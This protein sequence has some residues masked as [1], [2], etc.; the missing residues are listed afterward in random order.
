[1]E[2]RIFAER[3]LTGDRLQ[4][5]LF[6]PEVLSDGAPGGWGSVPDAPGR[7]AE[8]PLRSKERPPFPGASQL[9]DS[10]AAVTALHAFANH[11]LLAIELMALALLR[12][13]DAD[14]AF[15]MD[16]ALTLQEEQRHLALYVERMEALGSPFG[17]RTLSAF[18]WDT[19]A[20][21]DSPAGFCA[22]MGLTL[23]QANLDF[24]G[25]FAEAFDAVGDVA[26]ARVL[27]RVLADEI[28]HVA[29]GLQWFDRFRVEGDRFDAYLAALPSPLTPRRA[30]G[31]GF[32]V[33]ARLR[34]G[35]DEDFI[36][37][38][39]AYGASRGRAAD[40]HWLNR[41]AE[42]GEG[43][44]AE[45]WIHDLEATAVLRTSP[46]DV[47]LVSRRPGVR[48]LEQVSAAG[49][50]VPALRLRTDG[51]GGGPV[52]QV[53][54]WAP[55]VAAAE[56][57][58]PWGEVALAPLPDKVADGERLRQLLSDLGPRER[59]MEPEA[60]P[61]RVSSMAEVQEAVA[62]IRAS[63]F[64][65]VVFKRPLGT[66]GQGQLRLF[67]PE[68]G[69]GQCR[70]LER[71][72]AEG[73]LRVEPW[74][75]RVLDLSFQLDR[76]G[77]LG[78]VRFETDGTGRFVGASLESPSAGLSSE[79]ARF[80]TADGHDPRWVGRVGRALAAHLAPTGPAGVDAFVYRASD[81]GLRLHP[82]AETNPR[83]TFGR[84]ALDLRR[85][86][87]S[88]CV[89]Q[90]CLVG[91][92]A[93]RRSG[94]DSLEELAERAAED[95]PVVLRGGR[96]ASCALPTADP[97]QVTQVLPLLLVA[98]TRTQLS[99]VL[100]RLGLGRKPVSAG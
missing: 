51:P 7:P 14:P 17:C 67:E 59:L 54:P 49:F 76:T 2:L 16:L 66:S 97:S 85:R 55:T 80:W 37:R 57:L 33:T 47:V 70:W 53:L 79:L 95:L 31:P 98:G 21:V 84:L 91:P 77:L 96:L 65:R 93:L 24:A 72:L 99:Q 32:A 45:A 42:A 87:A 22:A 74:L 12:F 81:G 5:K 40:I 34:A 38:V 90:W 89:G 82:W 27:R 100:A 10:E 9:G 88:G 61:R 68:L 92:S 78:S 30:R 26:S 94:A 73:P 11:E 18:F 62:D 20:P 86:L 44:R 50:A 83:I 13:D 23:E 35:L 69:V 19:L 29:R 60:L 75:E 56:A 48:W 52:R 58:A 64:P 43:A 25:H 36:Q 1:M 39:R 41:P 3:V 46:D 4:D 6:A 63:G 71:G 28:R 15:R 8:L